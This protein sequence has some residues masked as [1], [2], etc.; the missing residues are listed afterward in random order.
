[1]HSLY[2]GGGVEGGGSIKRQALINDRDTGLLTCNE[3][4]GHPVMIVSYLTHSL[5]YKSRYGKTMSQVSLTCR[6]LT[7]ESKSILIFCD[8]LFFNLTRFCL[9]FVKYRCH[10]T[11]IRYQTIFMISYIQIILS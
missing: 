8:C 4:Y 6:S 9:A 3:E 10:N 1:M 11:I 5:I 2:E 7:G